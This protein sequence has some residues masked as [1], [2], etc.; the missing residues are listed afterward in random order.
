M[1][2]TPKHQKAIVNH[3]AMKPPAHKQKHGGRNKMAFHGTERFIW[4]QPRMHVQQIQIKHLLRTCHMRDRG[5]SIFDMDY[6][7]YS[8]N[9]PVGLGD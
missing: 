3:E 5:L 7:I 9:H 4:L 1:C 6:F 2:L 8:Q